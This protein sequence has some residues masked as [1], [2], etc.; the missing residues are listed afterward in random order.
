[1]KI[2]CIGNSA[3]DITVLVDKYPEENKKIRLEKNVVECGGG[4]ASNCAYL[5]SKW[6][7]DTTIASIVGNDYYGKKIEDEY[8]SIKLNTKY[9]EKTNLKTPTSY[10]IA[11]ISNGSRTILINRDKNIKFE[12]IK[13]IDDEYDYILT[14]GG[15]FK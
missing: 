7:I 12:N 4:S 3:Y 1:M 10:I 15:Y 6:G 5:L 2:L 9:L 13:K 8:K 14:D 11:N